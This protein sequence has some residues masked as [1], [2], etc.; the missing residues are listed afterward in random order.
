MDI[1][2]VRKI[3]DILIDFCG[4][5]NPNTGG[6]WL[7]CIPDD[8]L[9]VLCPE[10]TII[11]F[12]KNE[13]P[14]TYDKTVVRQKL[15][16]L[17]QAQ[18]EANKN[19]TYGDLSIPGG[20][21]TEVKD[22]Y[23]IQNEFPNNYGIN[24]N[25]LPSTASTERKALAKQFKGYL[26][27]F[28]QMLSFY[29]KHLSEV[30]QLF[31]ADDS[32]RKSYF[33]QEING[34]KDIESLFADYSTLETAV[35][36]IVAGLDNYH[37]RKNKFLD[38]LIARFAER[39][40]EYTFLLRD[41]FTENLEDAIISHKV[42]FL[43]DYPELSRCR[44]K[45]YNYLFPKDNETWNTVNVPGL[46][47]R[48]A[49]LTGMRSY[50]RHDLSGV[51]YEIYQEKDDDGIDEYRWRIRDKNSKIILSSSTRYLSKQ[52]A[53]D[54]KWVTVSLA[55]SRAN[56]EIKET[57]NGKFYFNVIDKV[58]EVVGRRI[59]Y[60]SSMEKT[61]EAI[62]HIIDFMYNKMADEGM[63]IFEH[64][65]LLPDQDPGLGQEHFLPVCLD[66]NCEGCD[67]IDPYSFRITVV[68]PGWT[69]RFGNIDFRK[70]MEKTIRM[71]CPAHILP[72]IC[73]ISQDQMTE[74]EIVYKNWLEANI[75]GKN[76]TIRNAAL[77]ALLEVL[78]HL[79]TVYPEGKLYDCKDPEEEDNPIILN[80]TNLGNL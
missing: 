30:R 21:Y 48:I 60:Y 32:I 10:K 36:T 75:D 34:I 33:S 55:W 46:Q 22:Y 25:G 74:I 29:M 35:E 50:E 2:G 47:K 16:S 67:P 52:S 58:G 23:T 14:I 65:L 57:K 19:Y 38:H 7:L 31:E 11:N 4:M 13:L 26:V 80:R 56:Y 28:D 76:K 53:V 78:L 3:N 5:E 70:F 15:A 49:R 69:N 27:V 42:H 61:E 64:I 37:E 45:S 43:K 66:K 40:N 20:T 59:E 41:L 51:L 79:H 12:N 63:Y 24:Q 72:K 71:E 73:W 44:A 77:K 9:P 17:R 18:M 6:K 62:A 1:S 8:H 39:F 54:E 68:L